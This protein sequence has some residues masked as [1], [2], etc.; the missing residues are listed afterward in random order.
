[1]EDTRPTDP[2][3]N[4]QNRDMNSEYE[5]NVALEKRQRDPSVHSF[6]LIDFVY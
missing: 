4:Q 6:T 1:M 5:N 3:G 2:G